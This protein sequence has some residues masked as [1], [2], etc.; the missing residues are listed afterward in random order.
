MFRMAS[1]ILTAAGYEHYEVGLDGMTHAT[2]VAGR[3]V[4][5]P[6][7]VSQMASHDT[8]SCFRQMAAY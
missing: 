6:R 3:R 7:F 2:P 4:V 1:Q 5:N 8:L